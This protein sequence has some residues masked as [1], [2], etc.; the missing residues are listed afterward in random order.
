MTDQ[1]VTGKFRRPQRGADSI[2]RGSAGRDAQVPDQEAT[3]RGEG[4][5]EVP[6][7]AATALANR[8]RASGRSS[9]I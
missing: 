1:P 5:Q 7:K 2:V 4:N 3:Q 9:R 8:G 6:S